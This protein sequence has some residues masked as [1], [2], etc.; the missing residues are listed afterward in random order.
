MR[1]CVQGKSL[2]DGSMLWTSAILLSLALAADGASARILRP[3]DAAAAQADF[4]AFRARMVAAVERRDS[5][6]LLA[7]LDPD[8]KVSFGGD[9][10]IARFSEIWSPDAADSRLWETLAAVLALGG[11]FT[12]ADTFTAPYV[13][14]DWP[15]DVDA[16]E[17]AAIVGSRVRV[18]A[19]PTLEAPAIASL[20][21][22]IVELADR[23]ADAD[24]AWVAV[25]LTDG[26]TGFVA[27]RYVRS[28]LDYRAIFQKAGDGWRLR[29]FVA[30]D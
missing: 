29:A 19:A 18:R 6:A 10:G 17:H 7:M 24:D 23:A 22:A 27:R 3:V 9:D 2:I 11:T 20:S 5:T 21:Y 30:G 26:R 25:R 14:A 16:F 13:F 4:A 8:I 12:Q 1:L 15:E 28:P